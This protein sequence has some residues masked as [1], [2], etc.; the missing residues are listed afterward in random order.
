MLN[1]ENIHKQLLSEIENRIQSLKLILNEMF[2]AASGTDAKSSAGDKHETGVAMAQLEQEKLTKQINELLKQ[3]EI[4]VRIN[5]TIEH[6][7]VGLGS[8]VQTNNGWYYFSVGIGTLNVENETV[9][10][11]NPKAPIGEMLIGK[12]AGEKILFNGKTT[13]I[14]SVY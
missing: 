3:Q 14:V 7:K 4:L 11:L 12:S 5:P 8:L 13:E 2:E 10:A 1:K 9:F 6:T